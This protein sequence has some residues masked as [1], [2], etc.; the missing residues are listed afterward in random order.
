MRMRDVALAV[1]VAA[2]WGFAFVA[3][4]LGLRSFTPPQLAALRFLLAALP[5]LVVPR[6]PVSWGRLAA[7]GA[8]LFAGQFLLLFFGIAAG[9]PP[10]LASIVTQLQAFFRV[11]IAALALGDRPTP[12]QRAGMGV[13]FAGLGLIGLTIG[14]DLTWAGLALTLGGALSWAVGNVLVKRLDRVDD[15]LGLMVWLS[16]VPP[17][18]A[19]ALSGVLDGW[20]A[21]PAALAGASWESLGG[22]LYLGLVAT[23]FAYAVWGRLLRAYPTALVAPFALLAPCTGVVSSALLLGER[24]GVARGAGMALILAGLAITVVPGRRRRPG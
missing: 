3:T 6:P 10:G 5:V 23:V 17:L 14:G 1:L 22:A 9:M 18:P 11:A 24:F 20:S 16:L 21:L 12:R 4:G 2:I 15:M 8:F 19:L 13:A 7:I